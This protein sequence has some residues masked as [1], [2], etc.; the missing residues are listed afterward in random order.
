MKIKKVKSF[1]EIYSHDAVMYVDDRDTN[2]ELPD[3]D[4]TPILI[5]LNKG[6]ICH[7]ND[8]GIISASSKRDAIMKLN[9]IEF[10][11]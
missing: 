4:R 5:G 7:F 6:Y 8:C 1:K 10:I 9:H 2:Y 11:K 3:A